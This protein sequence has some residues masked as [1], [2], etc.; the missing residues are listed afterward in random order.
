MFPE[1]LMPANELLLMGTTIE[2][3]CTRSPLTSK[4]LWVENKYYDKHYKPIIHTHI[5]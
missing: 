4:V 1:S 3:Y 5:Q 2:R